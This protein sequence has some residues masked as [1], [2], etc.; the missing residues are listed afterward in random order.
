M[1][2]HSTQWTFKIWTCGY[3][4]H[5]GLVH[6]DE[7]DAGT[8]R[9][10]D[11]KSVPLE[12]GLSP[13]SGPAGHPPAAMTP[14]ASAA[15]QQAATSGSIHLLEHKHSHVHWVNSKII[16]VKSE[17]FWL[18]MFYSSLYFRC[19]KTSSQEWRPGFQCFDRS[20]ISI[21]LFI[22]LLIWSLSISYSWYIEHCFKLCFK[23]SVE[24]ARV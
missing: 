12:N 18:L 7:A 4:L 8:E 3:N 14:K 9:K 21:M 5:V 6:Q 15:N 13:A 22:N 16:E 17:S 1:S 10:N 20:A 19:S 2:L 11:L 23:S 24:D